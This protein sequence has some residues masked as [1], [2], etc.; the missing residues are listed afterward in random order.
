MIDDKLKFD[1]HIRNLCKEAGMNIS[2]LNRLTRILSTK[3]RKVIFNAYIQSLFAYGSLV[4]MFC[5]RSENNRINRLHKRVLR[6]IYDD[7]TSTFQE[8]L[9]RDGSVS[10]H[11]RSIRKVAIEIFEVH[12]G[13]A[14]D[15]ISDLFF[16]AKK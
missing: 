14:P 6:I 9:D 15:V 16:V 10:F 4:W 12:Q 5:N 11:V 8:L 1:L 13:I 3:K 7:T 2:A